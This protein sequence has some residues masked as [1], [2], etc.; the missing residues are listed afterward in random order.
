MNCPE[1]E[2]DIALYVGDDLPP[3]RIPTVV[4]HLSDCAA[5]RAF[6]EEMAECGELVHSLRTVEL[7][8]ARVDALRREVVARYVAHRDRPRWFSFFLQP[9]WATAMFA[10]I[11]LGVSFGWF[12]LSIG[13]VEDT[14]RTLPVPSKIQTDHPPDPALSRPEPTVLPSRVAHPRRVRPVASKSSKPIQTKSEAVV[15]TAR[16]APEPQ[17]I[18]IQTADPNVRIIWFVQPTA[19]KPAR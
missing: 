14:A 13:T 15:E 1:F 7:A 6:A 11:L 5:C 16:V 3:G 2:T 12:V 10:V 4:A 19:E 18:E 8:P 9:R 17:R